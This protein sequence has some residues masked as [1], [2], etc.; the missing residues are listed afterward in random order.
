MN[1]FPVKFRYAEALITSAISGYAGDL[2]WK[3]IFAT[4]FSAILARVYSHFF[5]LFVCLFCCGFFF[6]CNVP[7][8]GKQVRV[9][10]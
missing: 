8:T 3:A 6:F 7:L 5:I 4:N 1:N 9:G 2:C 10:K